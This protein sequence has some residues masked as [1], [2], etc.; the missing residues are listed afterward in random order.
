MEVIA[1]QS[2]EGLQYP[3]LAVNGEYYDTD[4]CYKYHERFLADLLKQDKDNIEKPTL[5]SWHLLFNKGKLIDNSPTKM[6]KEGA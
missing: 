6:L 1:G 3:L 5:Y 2:I 4:I